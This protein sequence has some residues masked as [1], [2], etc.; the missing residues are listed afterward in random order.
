MAIKGS[1]RHFSSN[2]VIS[3]SSIFVEK[4]TNYVLII[5]MH[6]ETLNNETLL[7][8]YIDLTKLVD[9]IQNNHLYFQQ[10]NKYDDGFEG[11]Y[12]KLLYDIADCI[13]ITG[14]NGVKSGLKERTNHIR[15][16]NYV[17]CWTFGESHEKAMSN[18]VPD[19]ARPPFAGRL[20]PAAPQPSPL[21]RAATTRSL[22]LVRR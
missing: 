15:Q 19:A 3:A 21:T 8:R 6:K 13:S 2:D 10:L 11:C 14:V 12:P 22:H 4:N 16:A 1:V 17:N 18:G 20:W 7:N 5:N 9:L